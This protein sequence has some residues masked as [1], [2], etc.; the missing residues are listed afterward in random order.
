MENKYNFTTHRHTI[1][2]QQIADPKF[3]YTIADLIW[4]AHKAGVTCHINGKPYYN[5]FC[6]ASVDVDM[7]RDWHERHSVMGEY[8]IQ[9]TY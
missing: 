9:E 7:E 5:P 2:P 3:G 4:E 8:V 6:E 1:D